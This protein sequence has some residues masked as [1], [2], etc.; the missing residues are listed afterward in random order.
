MGRDVAVA[1][2]EP[3][4]V[5]AVRLQLVLCAPRLVPA[6]PPA[7]DVDALAER[8]HH[9]VEVGTD[10]EAVDPQVVGRVGDD[11]DLASAATPGSDWRSMP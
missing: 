9:G 3:R 6:A 8:V 11:G 7:V 2:A 4:R 1:Q 5:H 10:L